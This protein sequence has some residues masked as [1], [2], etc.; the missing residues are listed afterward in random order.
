M[1]KMVEELSDDETSVGLVEASATATDD[2][3][4][5]EEEDTA[6][7]KKKSKTDKKKKEPGKLPPMS[8]QPATKD[9]REAAAE[10][11]RAWNRRR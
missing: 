7:D 9:S 2:V 8:S 10:A 11:L 3:N 1:Q 6:D 5:I 4:E